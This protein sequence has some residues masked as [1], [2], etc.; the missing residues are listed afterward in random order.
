MRDKHVNAL[1][2][3]IKTHLNGPTRSDIYAVLKCFM[4]FNTFDVKREPQIRT[5]GDLIDHHKRVIGQMFPVCNKENEYDRKLYE[6]RMTFLVRKIK[7][8]C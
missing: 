6:A 7:E 1:Y 4:D 2:G 3:F 8:T 5:V